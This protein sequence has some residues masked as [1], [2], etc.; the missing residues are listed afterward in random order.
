MQNKC[1]SDRINPINIKNNFFVGDRLRLSSRKRFTFLD[2]VSHYRSERRYRSG[3]NTLLRIEG[4]ALKSRRCTRGA[5]S[6]QGLD[7]P[8][9]NPHS[10]CGTT[11]RVVSVYPCKNRRA[12]RLQGASRVC[13]RGAVPCR[14]VFVYSAA[15]VRLKKSQK[16]VP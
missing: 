4:L 10:P 12:R 6:K 15:T 11:E 5:A 8:D 3:I 1:D 9:E 14:V 2:F 13:A 7:W 16:R